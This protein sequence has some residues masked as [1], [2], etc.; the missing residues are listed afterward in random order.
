M[1]ND[2]EVNICR[3]GNVLLDR[4]MKLKKSRVS[5][6]L[7][8]WMDKTDE[9]MGRCR[10]IECRPNE[11]ITNEPARMSFQDRVMRQWDRMKQRQMNQPKR[12]GGGIKMEIISNIDYFRGI[13]IKAGDGDDNK[14]SDSKQHMGR[15]CNVCCRLRR[16]PRRTWTV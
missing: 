13:D 2:E 5:N 1:S 11:T 8:S 16:P 6:S 4:A 3:V 10:W 15:T 9:L 7:R 12:A 14:D